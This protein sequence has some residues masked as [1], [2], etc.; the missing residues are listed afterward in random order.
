MKVTARFYNTTDK[1]KQSGFL[2]NCTLCIEDTV[3][4]RVAIR[5]KKDGGYFVAYPSTKVGNDYQD[6]AYSLKRDFNDYIISQF[7]DWKKT[8]TQQTQSGGGSGS[9]GYTS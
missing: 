4:I 7:E 8:Q 1:A 9:G 2:A 5:Q 3:C 6:Q